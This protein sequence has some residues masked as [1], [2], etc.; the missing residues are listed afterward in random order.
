MEMGGFQI[1]NATL[2]CDPFFL[3]C[4]VTYCVHRQEDTPITPELALVEYF[5]GQQLSALFQLPSRNFLPHAPRPSEDYSY[6]IALIKKYR[7]TLE[8]LQN[9]Q[10][11]SLYKKLTLTHAPDQTYDQRRAWM[12]VNH[13]I[14]PSW[15][16]TF[17]YR[18]RWD[19]CPTTVNLYGISPDF[20]SLCSLCHRTPETLYHT[21]FSC[22]LVVPVWQYVQTAIEKMTDLFYRCLDILPDRY[23]K[24][25]R[26]YRVI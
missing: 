6:A 16:K 18:L 24:G 1:P 13:P 4:I 15:L 7:L 5:C 17:N 10:I 19:I 26:E 25:T 21:I 20:N 14:L 9:Y 22:P 11:R 23:N 2:Y 12:N 8:D 3:K